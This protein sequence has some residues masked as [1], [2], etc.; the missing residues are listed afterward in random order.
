MN[1]VDHNVIKLKLFT[2]SLRDKVRNWFNNLM[3]GSIDTWGILVKNFLTKFFPPQL[4]SQFRAEITQF[5]QVDQETLY[6]AWDIFKELLRKCPQHWYELS[7]QVQI[8]YNSHNYST[9]ALVDAACGGSI[10]MKIATEA[11][12]MFEEL[13]KKNYQPPSKRGDGKKQGGIHE[14]ERMSYLEAK[15]EAL[16][17]KLNQQAPKELTLREIAYM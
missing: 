16:M 2:F 14:I 8:F 9:R 5:R 6:N 12:L 10:T 15:F 1:G 13:E 7:A 17:T 4:T 3:S 11:N